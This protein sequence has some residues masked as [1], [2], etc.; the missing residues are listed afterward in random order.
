MW[1]FWVCVLSV[2]VGDVLSSGIRRDA[3]AAHPCETRTG[4]A[5]CR[6][7]VTVSFSLCLSVENEG[8]MTRGQ[9]LVVPDSSL[10]V[11]P[12]PVTVKK[13]KSVFPPVAF[14][15]PFGPPQRPACEALEAVVLGSAWLCSLG[16]AQRRTA[17]LSQERGSSPLPLPA[18]CVPPDSHR[19]SIAAKCH[20]SPGAGGTSPPRCVIPAPFSRSVAQQHPRRLNGDFPPFLS[21]GNIYLSAS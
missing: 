15:W 18:P 12:F 11:L 1:S 20:S 16:L 17:G 4:W 3:G 5:A 9:G 2:L 14:R 6:I 10:C 8:K 21:S 13:K 19:A 7:H